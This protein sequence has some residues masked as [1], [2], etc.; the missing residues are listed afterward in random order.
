MRNLD[1]RLTRL[2]KAVMPD[3]KRFAV[4]QYD[5]EI[6]ALDEMPASPPAAG[7]VYLPR[8]G[9]ERIDYRVAS[10][11]GNIAHVEPTGAILGL[12]GD[13]GLTLWLRGL[14]HV[15]GR[16]GPSVG[17]VGAID[18][19]RRKDYTRP[20]CCLVRDSTPRRTMHPTVCT[21]TQITQ[22]KDDGN[23]AYSIAIA[24]R[25]ARLRYCQTRAPG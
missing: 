19:L 15:L 6:V 16:P 7:V 18:R 20:Q 23:D 22:T 13:S 3:G 4:V 2:E 17:I 24:G 21:H 1:K 8:N 14:S 10:D 25:G 12:C 9:R 5:I 11:A